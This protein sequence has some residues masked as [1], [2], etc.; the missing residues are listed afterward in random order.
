MV[1]PTPLTA[2]PAAVL[3]KVLRSYGENRKLLALLTLATGGVTAVAASQL[4]SLRA[5]T[6][7]DRASAAVVLKGRAAAG[8]PAAA[9]R[10][11]PKPPGL[12]AQFVERLLFILRI[13][14]PSWRSP[15]A[16]ML[17]TQ[18]VVLVSRSLLSLRMARIGGDGL[19]ARARG[20]ARA[21]ASRRAHAHAPHAARPALKHTHATHNLACAHIPP[22]TLTRPHAHTHTHYAP[23]AGGGAQELARVRRVPCGLFR[24]W[25]RR[26]RHQQRH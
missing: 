19:K 16:F 1:A 8:T 26:E 7:A 20:S 4:A 15:E 2:S 14:V 22:Q 12:D 3:A 17:A 10:K 25:H 9:A 11:G 21:C 13:A 5:Q 6:K 24:D 18:S 23:P